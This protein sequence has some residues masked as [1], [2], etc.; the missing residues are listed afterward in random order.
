[1]FDD[2]RPTI[3]AAGPLAGGSAG[4]AP[5]QGSV[6]ADDM[7]AS[8][9][10]AGKDALPKPPVFQ[11]KE[12]V[13]VVSAE[14]EPP[15]NYRKY[16]VLFGLIL[17]IAALAGGGWYGYK[18]FAAKAPAVTPAPADNTTA[19]GDNQPDT[20]PIADT[21]SGG[22]LEASTTALAATSSPTAN[23][24]TTTPVTEAAAKDSDDDG[25]PDEEELRL[26]TNPNSVD[27]DNDG[28]FDREEVK[29]WGNDPLK[30][31]TD[32]DGY[33]DGAEVKGGYNPL[34]W[35]KLFDNQT[36]K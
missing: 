35:G 5:A 26:G 15:A 6:A 7:F 29:V 23:P 14:E 36:K 13:P 11:P 33:K 9:E 27:S 2:Q 8:V 19:T 16:L 3:P 32:G 24:A 17:A 21:P 12:P 28:L 20:A 10:P 22:T 25:L 4:Q 18:R 31:D 1:M 34:G 30:P